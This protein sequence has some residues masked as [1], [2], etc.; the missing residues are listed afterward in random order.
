MDYVLA[1]W[2]FI[3]GTALP[4]LFVLTVVVFFH[5]LGHFWIARLC[6]IDVK[7]FSVGFGPE[8]FGRYDKQGTRWKVSAIPLGGYVK[9]A[10]DENVASAQTSEA[11]TG[12]SDEE[13]ARTFAAKPV[14]QR[15]AVVAAGPIAN[16]ILAIAIFTVVFSLVGETMTAPRV[17]RIVED[18]AA[19]E[20]GFQIGDRIIAINGNEI[21]SFN[22]VRRVVSA[23]PGLTLTMEVE[24][25]NEIVSLSVTPKLQPMTDQ[26]GGTARVGVLGVVHEPSDDSITSRDYTIGQAFIKGVEETGFII[27]R[28]IGYVKGI[29]VGRE[30][31]DQLSGPIR[32]AKVSGDVATL[33][34]IPLLQLAA[35]LSVSIGLIN[36]FPIP[37]LDGGHL[38]YYAIEAV[39]GKPLSDKAQEIGFRMGMAAV[40]MLMVFATWNDIVQLTMS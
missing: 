29:I 15:A 26:F 14:S 5:E 18:S 23:S 20:A 22:D 12:M 6:K 30:S 28:T 4:F 38:V 25:N 9:F 39:R 24:R 33:G 7:A 8:L 13:R 10:G 27:T 34:F 40:L 16:F 21:E 11:L 36:L 32:V 19:E 35:I 3:Y 31:V 17:D 1:V 2:Q 37:L